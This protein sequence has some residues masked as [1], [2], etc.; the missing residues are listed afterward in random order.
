MSDTLEIALCPSSV[1]NKFCR[2]LNY[3]LEAAVRRFGGDIIT[4][5]QMLGSELRNLIHEGESGLSG[6]DDKEF[7]DPGVGPGYQVID[8]S[9]EAGRPGSQ[10]LEALWYENEDQRMTGIGQGGQYEQSS[11]ESE[12]L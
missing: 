2:L 8:V 6:N 11:L 5:M 3:E 1:A 9:G 4:Q 12:A 10:D 7:V